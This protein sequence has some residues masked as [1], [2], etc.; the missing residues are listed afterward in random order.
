M[1]KIYPGDAL[2]TMQVIVSNIPL[3]PEFNAE[4]PDTYSTHYSWGL[5][6]KSCV[7]T[8]GYDGDFYLSS[9]TWSD[10]YGVNG[11]IMMDSKA[12]LNMGG[13]IKIDANVTIE[14]V[15][16]D[17]NSPTFD[18]D[19]N[20]PDVVA[21]LADTNNDGEIGSADILDFLAFFGSDVDPDLTP[22]AVNF[23]NNV[24][25]NESGQYYIYQGDLNGDGNIGLADCLAFLAVFGEPANYEAVG[26]YTEDPTQ[27]RT[28]SDRSSTVSL[29]DLSSSSYTLSNIPASISDAFGGA[30]TKAS[31][32]SASIVMATV[33]A[34]VT[35]Y[36][37]SEDFPSN[38][39]L[40]AF[41]SPK[42]SGDELRGQTAELLLDLGQEDFELFAVNLNYE[43]LNAD[44]TK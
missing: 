22:E 1:A 36:V 41:L 43:L 24:V 35:T 2:G 32:T 11:S 6:S 31:P 34:D 28:P 7:N 33:D 38:A 29:V 10:T 27:A 19:F 30:Y 42:L 39:Q 17:P 16:D 23:G 25:Y 20:N 26:L 8:N 3:S 14:E 9:P 21:V 37:K 13:S 15:P 44:H 18:P 40:F 4:D 12:S 5:L